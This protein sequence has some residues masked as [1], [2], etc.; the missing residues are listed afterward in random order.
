M[1]KVI[2][3]ITFLFISGPLWSS[4]TVTI[5]T[6]TSVTQQYEMEITPYKSYYMDGQDQILFTAAELAAAGLGAGNIEALAFDV[7]YS[8]PGTLNSF[9]ISVQQITETSL[10]GFLISNW[11]V[12]FTGNI[13]TT[14]GW[15][16]YTF[17]TPFNWDGSSNLVF[18]VC[19]DNSDFSENSLV[20][21][22]TTPYSGV[23]CYWYNDFDT[24]SGCDVTES[25]GCDVA[26]PNVQ[27]TGQAST[28]PL[29]NVNPSTLDFGTV[30]KGAISAELFYEISGTNLAPASGNILVTPPAGF[31]ISLT[32]GGAYSTNALQIAY[33]GG[34]LN[35]TPVYAIFKPDAYY[36]AY[37]DWIINSGGSATSLN[38]AV[39]GFSPC[40]TVSL[41]YCQYFDGPGM[42]DCWYQANS[43]NIT[44]ARWTIENSDTA[45]GTEYEAMCTWVSE[46]GISRLISP[47]FLITGLNMVNIDFRQ[48]FD[49]YDAGLSD[50]EI[51]LQSRFNG[52]PWN[53]EWSHDGGI[54][55]AIPAEMK[56]LGIDVT[57]SVMELA[58]TVEG[59]HYNFNFWYLDDI[60]ITPSA[61]HDARTVSI[62]EVPKN[63]HPGSTIT[64]KATVQ[65]SG[66]SSLE[67]FS[68]TAIVPGIY[69]ST[70]TGITLGTGA[71][72]QVTFTDWTPPHPGV[73]S[74]EICTQ[75]E[76]DLKSSNN[77]LATEIKVKHPLYCYVAYDPTG[78]HPEGPAY[79]FDNDPHTLISLGVSASTQF[80][81]AATWAN[82]VWYGSEYWSGTSGGGWWTIDPA[83]GDMTLLASLGR[84]FTGLAYD[85]TAGILYGINYNGSSN[86]LYTI[87]PS[88]GISTLI[89]TIGSGELMINLA[90]DGL[91]YL[92]TCGL[93]SDHLFK[94]DPSGPTL[95]DIGATGVDLNYGQDMEY[96]QASNTMYAAAYSTAGAFYAVDLTTGA[97]SL[98]GMFYAGAEITGLAAPYCLDDNQWTGNV[99]SD[100]SNPANW[101]CGSVPD[102]GDNVFISTNPSGGRFP[103]ISTGTTAECFEILVAPG[104]DVTIEDGGTLTV[105]NP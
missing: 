37:D 102:D 55:S 78:V 91:G 60:C 92:Y 40:D 19:F 68:V 11:A 70:V 23:H 43:G 9:T 58:W 15:N 38:V 74:M 54:G 62:D 27:I 47:P 36:T 82:G 24:A 81:S 28:S 89:G 56:S 57:G 7:A 71:S 21:Y 94:I 96:D 88:T 79:F 105:N 53:T 48:M 69:S 95:I 17:T 99:S 80:I 103:F 4:V 84:G 33:S 32:T 52:G 75:L 41:P 50:V 86:D 22:T 97:F 29:L 44:S 90:T 13:T 61:Q 46:D 6:G 76:G 51:R 10:T 18:K 73:Y 66:S 42:P 16:T 35:A 12:C 3:L 72:T 5:G 34:S 85:L 39:F 98:I 65:N 14:E 67:T 100:W 2:V 26:R 83:N 64:P 101:T 93:S 104:A 20:Y 49:D 87:E 77:C 8:D 1:K 63:I 30:F 25:D 59:N 45:G 31:E